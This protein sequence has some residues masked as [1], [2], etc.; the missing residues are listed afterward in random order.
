M[1][2]YFRVWINSATL[3]VQANLEQRGGALMFIIG[4]FI[5]FGFFLTLLVLIA[6]R[7]DQVSGYSL[8]QLVI[9]FLFFNFFDM[10]GQIFFRG[11]YWFRQQ[12]VSGEFDFRLL[13]PINPLFQALTRQTDILD[14]PLLFIILAYLSIQALDQPLLNLIAFVVMAIS[15]LIIVTAIHIFVAALGVITTE[16]DH[17]IMIYRDLSSMA[18]VP[19]DIYA[20]PVRLF[21]TLIVPIGIAFTIPAKAFLG[22]LSTPLLLF[23]LFISTVF[24]YLSLRFWRYALTQYSS[25]SS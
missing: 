3:S 23:S 2:K 14:F 24:F 6:D 5:R 8:H 18:R 25:A 9:F 11:I 7:V 17:T 19:T 15:G 13:K 10:T 1:K 12:V 16:V 21:I 22:L 20:L 4:K